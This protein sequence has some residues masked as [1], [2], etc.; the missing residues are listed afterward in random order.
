MKTDIRYQ[1]D[2]E[3]PD[4]VIADLERKHG[5]LKRRV[6]PSGLDQ[7]QYCPNCGMMNSQCECW[8]AVNHVS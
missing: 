2:A 3:N 8:D 1:M 4:D 7:K 5:S 6:L